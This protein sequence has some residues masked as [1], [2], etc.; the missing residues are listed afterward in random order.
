MKGSK[1]DCIPDNNL[2]KEK[3]DRNQM[4]FTKIYMFSSCKSTIPW[5]IIKITC[6]EQGSGVILKYSVFSS[7]TIN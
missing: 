6:Q 2:Q 1:K 4:Q 5:T 3:R 7:L